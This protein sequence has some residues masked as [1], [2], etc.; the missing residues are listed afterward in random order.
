MLK[1]RFC[2]V[3]LK[4][5]HSNFNHV[6]SEPYCTYPNGKFGF[7]N[8]GLNTLRCVVGPFKILGTQSKF[9]KEVKKL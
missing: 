4:L 6:I 2:Y 1:V 3:P 7:E 9:Q 8:L 5:S